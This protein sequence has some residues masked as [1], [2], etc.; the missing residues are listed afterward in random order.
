MKNYMFDLIIN[1]AWKYQFL[2]YPNPAVG[3]AVIVNNQIF[4][5]VHKK[6]GE[7]HAEVNALWKAFRAFH[8]TPELKTSHEIHEFLL[9]NHKGFFNNANVFVTLEP[10]SHIGKT[11]S[12]AN[13]LKHLKPKSVNIGWPDPVKGHGGG[14]E[15]L[16]NAGIDVEILNDKRCFD[17]IE[18][19]I[20]WQK[21]FV[22]YKLALTMNGV[23]TGGYISSDKSLNWVHQVRDKIDL[24]VIGGN[25]V[26][27]DRPTLDARR[28]NG[29]APDVLI[30]SKNDGIERDIPLFNVKNRKVFIEETLEKMNDYKFIMIEGGERLYNEIKHTVDWKVFIVSPKFA[31]RF[32]FRSE[33]EFEILHTNRS[34][35]LIIFGR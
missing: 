24:L 22:F 15:I 33:D 27:I 29:K 1:E 16:K 3:A 8:K 20:K 2:T 13:L 23:I 19:F 21:R 30:Y 14:A 25:T 9:Q 32:N 18:P 34:D 28:I 6:A 35:D 17:L 7:P 5:G 4:T 26:R 10:C 11:P 12:C 31:N